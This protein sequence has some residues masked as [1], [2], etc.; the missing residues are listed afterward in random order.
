ML[1]QS[2]YVFIQ[3]GLPNFSYIQTQK[4]ES[5]LTILGSSL[6]IWMFMN[7]EI[8]QMMSAL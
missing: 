1:Y 3:A 2:N 8:L 5:F 4:I 6:S 7:A